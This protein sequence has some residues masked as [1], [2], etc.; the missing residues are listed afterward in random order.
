MEACEAAKP[1]EAT[2]SA[3]EG[4]AEAL[5]SPLVPLART[6]LWN[7]VM[8]HPDS[9]TS[10]AT[11]LW[12]GSQHF[13]TLDLVTP[14]NNLA[15]IKFPFT[16]FTIPTSVP[17][18]VRAV[19]QQPLDPLQSSGLWGD[20]FDGAL[21]AE[22]RRLKVVQ[23][24]GLGHGAQ[25]GH[26]N[27]GD[28]VE[29]GINCLWTGIPTFQEAVSNI[30]PTASNLLSTIPTSTSSSVSSSPVASK[31]TFDSD[32][33]VSS[34]TYSIASTASNLSESPISEQHYLWP[35]ELTLEE[36][37]MKTDPITAPRRAQ[38]HQSH[39]FNFQLQSDN[40][41]SH[42]VE[43]TKPQLWTSAKN[44]SALWPFGHHEQQQ[45]HHVGT[46]KPTPGVERGEPRKN[47]VIN[48]SKRGGEEV[49]KKVAKGKKR[50]EV[51]GVEGRLWDS[52]TAPVFRPRGNSITWIEKSIRLVNEAIA[53]AVEAVEAAAHLEATPA[54]EEVAKK[55]WLWTAPVA[56]IEEVKTP[57]LLWPSSPPFG[58]EEEQTLR[59]NRTAPPA[60]KI[61]SRKLWSKEL[62]SE[63]VMVPCL[64]QAPK[65]S[66]GLW[67]S[68]SRTLAEISLQNTITAQEISTTKLWTP[69]T[70]RRTTEA[71]PEGMKVAFL[72]KVDVAE[73]LP[74]FTGGMWGNTSAHVIAADGLVE[75]HVLKVHH[76]DAFVPS[77]LTTI[78]AVDD[79]IADNAV[80]EDL[81]LD[82]EPV[83][84]SLL[85]S[86][87]LQI[88]LSYP[89]SQLLWNPSHKFIA[90]VFAD[91]SAST[92]R[93]VRQPESAL[94][95]NSNSLWSSEIIA[96]VGLWKKE[97][98]MDGLWGSAQTLKE[99]EETQVQGLWSARA[100]SRRTDAKPERG[101]VFRR[102]YGDAVVTVTGPMWSANV[103]DN[104]NDTLQ[105]LDDVMESLESQLEAD[106]AHSDLESLLDEL[107]LSS[108]SLDDLDTMLDDMVLEYSRPSSIASIAS[109][110]YPALWAPTPPVVKI[111]PTYTVARQTLFEH[112][113]TESLRSKEV[114]DTK[115]AV[116]ESTKLWSGEKVEVPCLWTKKPSGTLWGGIGL[117]LEEMNATAMEVKETK[118]LWHVSGAKRTSDKEVIKTKVTKR[119]DVTPLEV[120][121]GGLWSKAVDVEEVIE[122][123]VEEIAQGWL[124][125][126]KVEEVK[127]VVDAL[128]WHSSLAARVT[129]KDV[130]KGMK[131]TKRFDNEPLAISSAALWVKP[132][133]PVIEEGRAD[134][135]W[136]KKEV[137][138]E[139]VVEV[140]APLVGLWIK[141]VVAPV[142]KVDAPMWHPALASRTTIASPVRIE[143][144]TQRFNTEPLTISSIGLW[145]KEKV[146]L[147][148][149]PAFKVEV[150]HS[151]PLWHADFASRVTKQSPIKVEK[152]IKRFNFAPLVAATGSLWNGKPTEVPSLWK[153][154]RPLG[155]PEIIKVDAPLWHISTASRTTEAPLERHVLPPVKRADKPLPVFTGPMWSKQQVL[156]PSLWQSAPKAQEC[157]WNPVS[158]PK[159]NNNDVALWKRRSVGFMNNVSLS[160]PSI[161]SSLKKGKKVVKKSTTEVPAIESDSL[162]RTASADAP[163]TIATTSTGLWSVPELTTAMTM[164]EDFSEPEYFRSFSPT[165]S[166]TSTLSDLSELP[167]LS[168]TAAERQRDTYTFIRSDS[169][170]S[171]GGPSSELLW[172]RAA[173]QQQKR[174]AE[175]KKAVFFPGLWT[176]EGAPTREKRTSVLV[177]ERPR[178]LSESVRKADLP[179]FQR[180]AGMKLWGNTCTVPEKLSLAIPSSSQE[181]ETYEEELE[182]EYIDTPTSTTSF[183]S[184]RSSATNSTLATS[185][186]ATSQRTYLPTN[187]ECRLMTTV[188]RPAYVSVAG[189]AFAERL[190]VGSL[191]KKLRPVV[192][193]AKKDGEMWKKE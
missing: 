156:E 59:F 127:E 103:I 168:P 37:G 44:L 123:V 133:E 125:E 148:K 32:V 75:E 77:T 154:T 49:V 46:W 98:K 122:E 124:W 81:E 118:G 163:S 112:H 192:G 57:T 147:W 78:T 62:A 34:P 28:Q 145:T 60:L 111:H 17:K 193:A 88:E 56:K 55:E 142:V 143:K 169:F 159:F 1:T 16:D 166:E 176:G 82:L 84:S 144:V 164:E 180:E 117:S 25:S 189:S 27:V 66:N 95:I 138:L 179:T 54:Q 74:V 126:K 18:R 61:S 171:N 29:G 185:I 79:I 136:G 76:Y 178:R 109:V 10:S 21:I 184:F 3:E 99:M 36:L 89:S 115:L 6:L 161:P 24:R 58:I 162:W 5:E 114:R 94:K 30:Y 96:P 13:D 33:Y 106:K 167:S 63:G 135:M 157:L 52:E 129:E 181:E 107:S 23:V 87:P 15:Q 68:E 187:I 121:G 128:L 40:L 47:L 7:N 105:T 174:E 11:A 151:A 22:R 9:A 26:L 102:D 113:S 51:K 190:R 85:W 175:E 131:V 104:A 64:W 177:T 35:S 12:P 86:P 116:L 153:S 90:P 19:T 152:V 108:P 170:P 97:Q 2:G 69:A 48:I 65:K 183:N 119:F 186:S 132:A 120:V 182:D 146:A 160:L 100:A 139:E 173:I 41:W 73:K 20:K 137:V 149:K 45:P 101:E 31:N 172:Q 71:K 43:T 140:Q 39:Q 14:R 165:R 93:F 42:P 92:L 70:A 188:E 38:F 80:A 110:I 8:T 191:R 53:V 72:R 150:F 67:G 83:N 91:T 155:L 4:V 158:P 141:P 50:A 130:I 134:G